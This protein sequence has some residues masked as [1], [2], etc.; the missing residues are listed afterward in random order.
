[1]AMTKNL[2][3]SETDAM[4]KGAEKQYGYQGQNPEK[5]PKKC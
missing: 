4:I 2:G 3:Q 1:M 5:G